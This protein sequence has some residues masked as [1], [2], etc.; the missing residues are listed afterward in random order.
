MVAEMGRHLNSAVCIGAIA[1]AILL[2]PAMARAAAP[3]SLSISPSYAPSVRANNLLA[4]TVTVGS[5][6]ASGYQWQVSFDGGVTWMPIDTSI[7]SGSPVTADSASLNIP[8]VPMALNGAKFRCLA[9]NASGFALSNPATLT[10]MTPLSSTQLYTLL[11]PGGRFVF[12]YFTRM[13]PPFHTPLLTGSTPANSTFSVG[14]AG[15]TGVQGVTIVWEVSTDGGT[16]WSNVSSGTHYVFYD[17]GASICIA[18]PQASDNGNLFRAIVTDNYTP[19]NSV[20]TM[21]GRLDV[22]DPINANSTYNHDASLNILPGDG[23]HNGS[24]TGKVGTSVTFQVNAS[25]NS[26]SLPLSY[27]WQVSTN[28]GSTWSPV[29]GATSATLTVAIASIAQNQNW[30]QCVISDSAGSTTSDTMVLTATP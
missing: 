6:S 4:L 13:A 22:G 30:Y 19:S 24:Q 28:F 17:N 16:T 3:G 23:T 2:S 25:G 20:T 14:F 5:G 9:Y 15:G 10:V 12:G 8:N 26:S 1:T 18:S 11:N 27:A 29:A 21:P 7:W